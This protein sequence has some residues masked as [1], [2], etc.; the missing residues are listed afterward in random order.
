MNL[1]CLE[2]LYMFL[3][4]VKDMGNIFPYQKFK[5]LEPYSFYFLYWWL[6]CQTAV[7]L[8]LDDTLETLEMPQISFLLTTHHLT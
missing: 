7:E 4:H 1:E 6:V 5:N 8:I 3:Q 2:L